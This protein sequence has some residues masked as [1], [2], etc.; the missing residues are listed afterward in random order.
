MKFNSIPLL[1]NAW[2]DGWIA[3]RMREWRNK[4]ESSADNRM[5]GWIHEGIHDWVHEWIHGWIHA[6]I[7]ALIH[8]WWG[9]TQ[10]N[11]TRYTVTRLILCTR[12]LAS[13]TVYVQP[14]LLYRLRA[15]PPSQLRPAPCVFRSR[16]SGALLGSCL[17][18]TIRT[19]SETHAFC[20]MLV[21]MTSFNT[22]VRNIGFL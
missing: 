16:Y 14:C 21:R 22:S 17:A 2:V 18:S 8:G 3:E 5:H 13:G 7:H 4:D 6:W 12:K 15:T 19:R 20:N 10:A 9:K 1:N 11:G